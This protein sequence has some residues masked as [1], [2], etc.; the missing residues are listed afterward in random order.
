MD[1]LLDNI[2]FPGCSGL[3]LTPSGRQC[4]KCC[5]QLSLMQ[6]REEQPVAQH[7][8]FQLGGSLCCERHLHVT[9]GTSG[10]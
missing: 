6:T 1:L 7:E 2:G 10:S 4:E 5:G 9:W 3:Q 8:R